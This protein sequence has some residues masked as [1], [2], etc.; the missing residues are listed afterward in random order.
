MAKPV[1]TVARWQFSAESR[2]TVLAL[3]GD[4]AARSLAEPGCIGYD[5]LQSVDG[6]D[7][8]VLVE[9]YA[10]R[11]ALEAHTSSPHYQ[12]LVAGRIRPLLTDR[13]VH[14]LEPVDHGSRPLTKGV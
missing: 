11:A 9:R 7:D 5:V 6:P 12:D 10:D 3:V 14:I 1:V 8:L 2:A 4:L 13:Q